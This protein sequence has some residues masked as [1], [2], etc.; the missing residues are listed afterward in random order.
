MHTGIPS[1]KLQCHPSAGPSTG[2]EA[3]LSSSRE[4]LQQMF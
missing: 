4:M 2:H 1:L 3:A